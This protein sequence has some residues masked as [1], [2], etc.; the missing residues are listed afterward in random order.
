MS[1]KQD[2]RDIRGILEDE[3]SGWVS[4]V[5]D[6]AVANDSILCTFRMDGIPYRA[7]IAAT[8]VIDCEKISDHQSRSTDAAFSTTSFEDIQRQARILLDSDHFDWGKYVPKYKVGDTRTNAKGQKQIFNK[9]SR[10]ENVKGEGA[11]KS[12]KSKKTAAQSAT[13]APKTP[14]EANEVLGQLREALHGEEKPAAKTKSTRAKKP[15]EKPAEATEEKPKRTRKPKAE[16]PETDEPKPKATRAKKVKEE[17]PEPKP[18]PKPV[19]KEM[20]PE[21]KAKAQEVVK[22]S[23]EKSEPKP[24]NLDKLKAQ[25]GNKFESIEDYFSLGSEDEGSLQF[26]P[27][28]ISRIA[29]HKVTGPISDGRLKVYSVDFKVNGEYDAGSLE[30]REGVKAAL[31]IR[32]RLTE[33]FKNLPDGTIVQ[34]SPWANDGNGDKRAARYERFGFGKVINDKASNGRETRA[35]YGVVVNGKVHP[36]DAESMQSIIKRTLK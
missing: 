13:V 34:N 23:E 28:D 9:N 36:L 12:P 1:V 3:L 27:V 35:Q 20:P 8:G 14:E 5:T 33:V 18:E 16:K 7:A 21:A 15:A 24:V 11:S 19:E 2:L 22:R 10:W 31:T 6:Y 26:T 29:S 25:T 30:G 32:K 4:S 17:K